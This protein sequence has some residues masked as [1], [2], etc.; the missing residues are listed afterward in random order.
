MAKGASTTMGGGMSRGLILLAV[1][2]GLVAAVLVFAI[3]SRSSDEN[4]GT[5]MVPKQSVVVAAQDIPA[6]TR[7]TSAMLEV[8][9]VPANQVSAEAFRSRT[10][11]VNRVATQDVKAGQQVV[12]AMVSERAGEGLAFRTEPGM[13]AVSIQAKEVV[14]AGGNVVP[15]DQVDVIAIL[16]LAKD[17]DVVS[18]LATF[19]PGF[20]LVSVPNQPPTIV[21]F[22]YTNAEDKT[23]TLT[24]SAPNTDDRRLTLTLLQDVKVLAVAQTVM[25]QPSDDKVIDPDAK[26]S[27]RAASVTLEVTPEQSQ[28][29]FLADELGVLRL[30]VRP[31]GD[32]GRRA[33]QPIIVGIQD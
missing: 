29:L 30:A 9:Q 14:S 8:Q 6:R 20:K 7:I 27:Q 16:K 3:A 26:K 23:E 33:V 15:G 2:F 21:T 11:L 32:T 5:T 25:E 13:R 12:P 24:I 17:A 10:Q 31:Y 18:V 28:T 1:L 19:L 22:T 4:G